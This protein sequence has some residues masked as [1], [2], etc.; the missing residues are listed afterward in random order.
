MMKPEFS[1]ELLKDML[2]DVPNKK[3]TQVKEV[4][5]NAS[6]DVW[7]QKNDATFSFHI[8]GQKHGEIIFDDF[9]SL[10]KDDVEY[11]L[12][13]DQFNKKAGAIASDWHERFS[14]ISETVD[15]MM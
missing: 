12:N 3:Y 8:Q 5:I 14:L 15:S 13:R 6:I 1:F 9:V 2:N 4:G 11:V 7:Y 10:S